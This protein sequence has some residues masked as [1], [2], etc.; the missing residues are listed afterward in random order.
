MAAMRGLEARDLVRKHQASWPVT[1]F[2][3]GLERQVLDELVAGK[4]GIRLRAGK[5]ILVE[6][7]APGD[8]FLLIDALVKVTAR[9]GKGM[10]LLAVRVGGD[11]VGEMAVADGGACSATVTANRD[12]GLA[13]AVPGDEFLAV[14]G[15][16]PAAGKLLTAQLSRKLRAADRR[17][18]DFTVYKVP[19]RVA[20]VLAELADDYGRREPSRPATLTLRIGITQRELAT[21]VGAAESTVH[22]VVA[23]LEARNIL[24]WRYR[25]VEIHNIEALRLAASRRQP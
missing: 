12:G 19:E 13:V 9:L 15:R 8:V 17:R 10:A 2:L 21:L 18:V 7:E 4:R 6:G 14:I 11:I 24:A 22:E 20:R 25:A 5:A 3:A 23:E 1:S 16:H